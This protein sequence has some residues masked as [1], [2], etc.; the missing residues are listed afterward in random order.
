MNITMHMKWGKGLSPQK[1]LAMKV[2]LC[3]KEL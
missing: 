1:E 3:Q 2:S